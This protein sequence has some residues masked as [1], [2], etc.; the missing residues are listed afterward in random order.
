MDDAIIKCLKKEGGAAGM[1]MLVDA[2]KGLETKTKKLPKKLSA[3][4]KIKRYFFF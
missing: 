1:G 4:A 2:V 3:K